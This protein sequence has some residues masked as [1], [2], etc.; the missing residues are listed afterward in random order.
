[1]F[2]ASPHTPRMNLTGTSGPGADIAEGTA[3]GTAP[4]AAAAPAILW[5]YAGYSISICSNAL[6]S[7]VLCSNV[8]LFARMFFCSI[9]FQSFFALVDGS[10]MATTVMRMTS[11]D[12]PRAINLSVDDDA[13]TAIAME[14]LRAIPVWAACAVSTSNSVF[15]RFRPFSP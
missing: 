3:C 15:L 2:G 7:N 9:Y 1:M 8:L 10:L 11:I 14:P 5:S 6:Y 12:A 4:T 13:I